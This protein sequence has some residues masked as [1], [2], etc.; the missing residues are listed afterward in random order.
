MRIAE[1]PKCASAPYVVCALPY[2]YKLCA[3]HRIARLGAALLW[4]LAPTATGYVAT[5]PQDGARRCRGCGWLA[6]I[7]VKPVPFKCVMVIRGGGRGD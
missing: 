6:A 7:R 4:R 2:G 5:C 3:A 1:A